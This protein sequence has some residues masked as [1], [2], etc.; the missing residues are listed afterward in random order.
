MKG[1]RLVFVWACAAVLIMAGPAF[2]HPRNKVGRD[3][4]EHPS[5]TRAKDLDYY[6]F[7]NWLKR[8]GIG[9]FN[10]DGITNMKDY[11]ILVKWWRIKKII[12]DEMVWLVNEIGAEQLVWWLNF[13]KPNESWLRKVEPKIYE[14]PKEDKVLFESP[15]RKVQ[16]KIYE[17]PKQ[18]KVPFESR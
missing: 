13:A 1:K 2:G 10:G 12:Y 8:D 15:L 7:Q 17:Q 14:P 5:W 4:Y 16:P 11:V 9:D 6:I 18:E 3:S